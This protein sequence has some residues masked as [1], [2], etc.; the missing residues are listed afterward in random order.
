[1]PRVLDSTH[2]AL[3]GQLIQR[4]REH[5]LSDEVRAAVD[6]LTASANPARADQLA[7]GPNEPTVLVER[8]AVWALHRASEEAISSA[9][10]LL[11][12]NHPAGSATTRGATVV[13]PV[14]KPRANGVMDVGKPEDAR[15]VAGAA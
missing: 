2:F 10:R 9:G 1:M 8:L 15:V 11:A 6:T 4:M 5:G 13:R 7:I 14:R 3:L 12:V